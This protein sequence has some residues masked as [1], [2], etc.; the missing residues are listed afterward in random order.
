MSVVLVNGRAYDH[1]Q[2]QV[3]YLGV[4]LPSVTTLDYGEE[5]DKV[6][7]HGSGN[8]PVSFGQGPIDTNGSVEMSMNDV[9]AIRDAAPNGSLLQIPL[10]DMVV[11]FSN[12][13]KPI[14][15]VIKNIAWITDTP[16]TSQGDT[17]IKIT[18][19]FVASNIKWR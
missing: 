5:Q 19:D 1:T 17:D 15:H 7:N 2:L 16:T 14:T 10:G 13:Q 3:I 18:L 8:R 6:F 4:E 9:E 11:V 12:P